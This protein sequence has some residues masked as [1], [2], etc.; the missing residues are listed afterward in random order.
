MP[1]CEDQRAWPLT[2]LLICGLG[3]ELSLDHVP[4]ALLVAVGLQG[5]GEGLGPKG[6]STMHK[7]A[8]AA[9]PIRVPVW[10]PPSC[11]AGESAGR[12]MRLLVT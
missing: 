9:S 12:E 7:A 11:S 8:P 2:H 10:I 3:G 6:A 5:P 4:A 1:G